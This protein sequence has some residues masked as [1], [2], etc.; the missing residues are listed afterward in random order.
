MEARSNDYCSLLTAR[1][2]PTAPL[3][4]ILSVSPSNCHA[5]C[6]DRGSVQMF[7]FVRLRAR[8]LGN[9]TYIYIYMPAI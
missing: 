7:A 8:G 1:C 5:K 6:L 3:A 4:F 2:T 9:D